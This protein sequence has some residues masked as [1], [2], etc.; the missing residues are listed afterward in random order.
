MGTRLTEAELAK[1]LKDNPEVE[2]VDDG[3]PMGEDLPATFKQKFA[4]LLDSRDYDR[5]LGL[6]DDLQDLVGVSSD[7]IE[8]PTNW[9]MQA[10]IDKPEIKYRSRTEERA[11]QWLSDNT[12]A[13]EILY[14]PIMV[15][16]PSGN[17]T[18]DFML[19]MPTREL[20]FV[21][22]KGN[23]KAYQSGRSSKKSLIEASKTYWF[24][25]RWFSLV[26]IP[27]KRGGGWE[28]KEIV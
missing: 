8:N 1:M 23:W 26:S 24:L 11:H 28:F 22:V 12:D 6:L 9:K 19:R 3:R 7:V 16:M 14:E 21:E 5:A 13:I 25:G 2:L 17:Y 20:W 4:N 27:K 10:K 18:P 15:R